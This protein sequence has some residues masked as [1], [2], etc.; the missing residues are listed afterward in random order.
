MHDGAQLAG[1]DHALDFG[2]WRGIALIVPEAQLN[3][4]LVRRR[5]R[6]FGVGL[7]QREGLFGEDVLAGGSGSDDLL[8]M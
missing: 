6:A 5:H 2:L 7:V 4:G 1:V 8:G 3:A